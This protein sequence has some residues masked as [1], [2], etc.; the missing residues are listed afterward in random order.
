MLPRFSSNTP[1]RNEPPRLGRREKTVPSRSE[2]TIRPRPLGSTKAGLPIRLISSANATP[3]PME[4]K[5]SVMPRSGRPSLGL[6]RAARDSTGRSHQPYWRVPIRS[7]HGRRGSALHPHLWSVRQVWKK[8]LPRIGH[9]HKLPD[10]EQRL[11]GPGRCYRL[12][13][14]AKDRRMAGSIVHHLDSSKAARARDFDQ[15]RMRRKCATRVIETSG[16]RP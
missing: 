3:E 5:A 12:V 6:R 7:V 14:S 10:R 8:P 4:G 13:E 1:V 11:G 9:N 15:Q 2:T 16:G